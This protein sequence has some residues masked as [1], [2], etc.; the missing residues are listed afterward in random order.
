MGAPP[1]T[2]SVGCVG[3]SVVFEVG[4]CADVGA[5]GVPAPGAYENGEQVR[6]LLWPTWPHRLQACGA[7]VGASR[8]AVDAGRYPH[9]NQA[10]QTGRSVSPQ[11][12]IAAGVS[13]WSSRPSPARSQPARA[14]D[15]EG[16]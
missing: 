5:G 15:P 3:E 10:G 4:S 7:A 9:I 1:K 14:A 13:S 11:P 16:A 8:A 6:R 12:Y 2:R